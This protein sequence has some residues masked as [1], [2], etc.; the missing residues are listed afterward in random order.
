MTLGGDL[1][2]WQTRVV[3][4]EDQVI[5]GLNFPAGGGASTL[6]DVSQWNSLVLTCVT[7]PI[8]G[9]VQ[10]VFEW[11]DVNND[12]VTFDVITLA[13]FSPSDTNQGVTI[14]V[15]SPRVLIFTLATSAAIAL[16]VYGSGRTAAGLVGT[17]YADFESTVLA[18]VAYVNGQQVP[19]GHSGIQGWAQLEFSCSGT[20]LF[21]DL[22]AQFFDDAGNLVNM[23][24]AS[25]IEGHTFGTASFVCKQV[26]LPASTYQLVFI[27]R[28][29]ATGSVS[30]NLIALGH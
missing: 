6:L 25:T 24:I 5:A 19:L 15:R 20:T 30:V 13:S 21:G 8:T 27:A 22:I 11:A 16:T 28:S 14:P 10:L 3:L 17:G 7:Q 18:P 23:R 12:E 1:P 2:D 4:T 9:P 26:I 29:A